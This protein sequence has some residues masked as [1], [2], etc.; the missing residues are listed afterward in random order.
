MTRQLIS[1]AALGGLAWAVGAFAQQPVI[2][3]AGVQNAASQT[4]AAIPAIAPQMLVTILGQNLA[5]ST[6]VASVLPLP[7]TLGGASVTFNGVAAPL[8]YASPAQINAQVPSALSSLTGAAVSVVV[9]TP[10]G[11]SNPVPVYVSTRQLGVFTQPETGCGQAVAFN[12]HSDGSP[13]SLNT[14]QSSFDPQSDLGLAIFL[15]GLGAFADRLDGVL[16]TYNPADNEDVQNF[17]VVFGAPSSFQVTRMGLGY[18]GPAPYTAGVDQLNAVGQWSGAPQGCR[19]P[20]YLTDFETSASQLVDISIQDGGGVCTDPP[21]GT[22]GILTWESNLVSDV[23]GSSLSES[24]TAQFFEANGLG[25]ATPGPPSY[26]VCCAVLVQPSVCEASLPVGL[27]AGTLAL[28][29]P[30]IGTL[31]VPPTA[32]NGAVYQAVFAPGTITGGTYQITGMGGSQVGPF[33]AQAQ[34][35]APINITTSLAPGTQVIGATSGN[36]TV[37]WTGGD[38]RSVVSVQVIIRTNGLPAPAFQ[39]GAAVP[40]SNGS[41]AISGELCEPFFWCSPIPSGA[42]EVIVTQSPVPLTP[43]NSPIQPFSAPGLGQGGEVLW[44]YMFD[45]RGLVN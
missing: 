42:A 45:Y 11:A 19:V 12:I 35:P 36:F 13:L 43:A 29:G 37:Q 17:Q 6:A 5:A 30:G 32:Q 20:M 27:D 18:L 31:D 40:A 24:L 8:L 15:T 33:A 25:F 1:A 14:P 4:I 7:D 26:S 34:I 3:S 21:A 22:L 2:Q 38:D 28:S 44:N 9:T 41:I 39:V 23:S 16:W 10:V